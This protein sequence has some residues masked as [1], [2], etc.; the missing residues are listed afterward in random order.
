M[1]KSLITGGIML[2]T[3]SLLGGD[4]PPREQLLEAYGKMQYPQARRLANKHY[5]LPEARL[6]EAL[7]AVFDRRKQNL[8]FGLSELK[9]LY[10]DKK[11][12]KKIRLQAGL[13]YARA[14]QTLEMRKGIYSVA[15]NIDFNKIYETIKTDYPKQPEACFAA[16]YQAQALLEAGSDEERLKGL[17]L[18]KQFLV[19]YKGAKNYLAAV[20]ILL[21]DQYIVAYKNYKVSAKYLIDAFECG[22]ANK[23]IREK[24]LFRIGRIYDLKLKDKT[25]AQKYYNLFIK[26]YPNS[27]S[28]PI[29]KRYLR[30]MGVSLSEVK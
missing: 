29:V 19:S 20:N 5:K 11:L 15:D 14:A 1:K 2:I 27:S 4:P 7:A 21:A 16:I 28:V 13:A 17:A 9:A 12:D 6:V 3:G 25:M 23:R 26:E 18:L 24:V 10:H 8:S 22:I 30:A